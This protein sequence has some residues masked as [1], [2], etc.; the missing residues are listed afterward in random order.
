[1]DP[2]LASVA[3]LAVA[4]LGTILWVCYWL[5]R[6]LRLKV[7]YVRA[8]AIHRF[9]QRLRLRQLEPFAWRKASRGPQRVASFKTLGFEELGGFSVDELPGARL[10]VLQHPASRV[11]GLVNEHE[12]LGTWSDALVFVNGET[13][14]ILTSSI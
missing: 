3:L 2:L 10:F 13:Q 11:L 12:Q 7:A 9:P 8:A 6:R 4:C 1:M 5:R 14:P